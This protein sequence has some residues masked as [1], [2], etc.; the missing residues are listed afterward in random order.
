[1]IQSNRDFLFINDCPS[2]KDKS[3]KKCHVFVL[4]IVLI[5]TEY[6]VLMQK[7]FVVVVVI[8]YDYGGN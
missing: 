6:V 8:I 2:W 3:F 7:I 5:A 4:K 1:M